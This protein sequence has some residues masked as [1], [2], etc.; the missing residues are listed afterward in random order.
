MTRLCWRKCGDGLL[1]YAKGDYSCDASVADMLNDLQWES[2]K[3]CREQ[4][5]LIMLYNILKQNTYLPLDYLPVFLSHS[6]QYIYQFQIR[7]IFTLQEHFCNI[8]IGIVKYSF[9]ILSLRLWNSLPR[10][11]VEC[12]TTESFKLVLQNYLYGLKS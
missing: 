9:L 3:S 11:I 7:Y 8:Y 1:D 2:L 5:S 12:S 4:F 10:W 6:S